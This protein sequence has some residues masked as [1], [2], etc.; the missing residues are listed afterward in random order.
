V[1]ET[2]I[3]L[4]TVPEQA[5][6]NNRKETLFLITNFKE[7]DDVSSKEIVLQRMVSYIYVFIFV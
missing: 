7:M 5:Q 2:Q 6:Q 4:S 1:L 3:I